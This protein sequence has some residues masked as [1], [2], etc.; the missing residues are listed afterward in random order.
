MSA[1]FSSPPD[2][3]KQCSERHHEASPDA[4]GLQREG[5]ESLA[6]QA[7]LRLCCATLECERIGQYLIIGQ[8]STLTHQI[9]FSHQQSM[10]A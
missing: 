9:Q 7:L 3:Q 5:E 2:I 8:G 1:N 4:L 6:L 10:L